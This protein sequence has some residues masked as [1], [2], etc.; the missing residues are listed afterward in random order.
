MWI[1]GEGEGGVNWDIRIDMYTPPCVKQIASG[2]LL[3]GTRNLVWCSVMTRGVGWA[4]EVQEGGDVCTH[5]AEPLH[6]P[7]EANTVL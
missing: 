7:A 5:I 3:Y 2:D 1:R 6:C 4:G